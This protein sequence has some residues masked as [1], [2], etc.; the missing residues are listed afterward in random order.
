MEKECK[1]CLG[2]AIAQIRPDVLFLECRAHHFPVREDYS[3]KN[4]YGNPLTM[5]VKL[6]KSEFI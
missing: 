1:I 5:L 4:V 6:Y 3:G 2:H